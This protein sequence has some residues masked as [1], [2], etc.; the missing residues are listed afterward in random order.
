MKTNYFL[1]IPLYVFIGLFLLAVFGTMWDD[2]IN[3]WKFGSK[4]EVILATILTLSFI[5][6][7]YGAYLFIY[8]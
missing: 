7:V 8:A 1:I 6:V 2:A 5:S 3:Q 4:A